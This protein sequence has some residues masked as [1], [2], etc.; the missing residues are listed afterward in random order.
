[1]PFSQRS[2]VRPGRRADGEGPRATGKIRPVPRTS[3]NLGVTGRELYESCPEARGPSLPRASSRAAPVTAS[4][5]SMTLSIAACRCMGARNAIKSEP[6][7]T[8][9]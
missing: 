8:Y 6:S 2:T 1:M 5:Y 4:A 7:Q 3:E 9:A